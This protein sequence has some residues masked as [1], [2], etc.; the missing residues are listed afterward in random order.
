MSGPRLVAERAATTP[1]RG[2]LLVVD[3]VEAA[4]VVLDPWMTSAAVASYLAVSPRTI[5]RWTDLAPDLA[6]PCH[7]PPGGGLRLYRRSDVDAWMLAHRTV[8]R[9]SLVAALRELGLDRTA[10]QPR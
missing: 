5:D 3:R 9:P 1:P 2:R 4:R 6:L 10:R 7:R 8:G